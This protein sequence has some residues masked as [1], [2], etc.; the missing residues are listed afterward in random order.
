ML[1]EGKMKIEDREG[2][3]DAG[4]KGCGASLQIWLNIKK[5]SWK[6]IEF[7]LLLNTRLTLHLWFYCDGVKYF[8]K[9]ICILRQQ[10][11]WPLELKI[12]IYSESLWNPQCLLFGCSCP[13]FWYS[14]MI[15]KCHSYKWWSH[16]SILGF[17]LDSQH[18]PGRLISMLHCHVCP[19]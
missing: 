12:Y 18:K 13:N 14:C 10:N 3:R 1:V 8:C 11:Q 15:A 19:F 16:L 4:C 17:N 9:E 7:K 2:K 5:K 6:T